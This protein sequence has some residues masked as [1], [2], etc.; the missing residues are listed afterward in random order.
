MN[1]ISYLLILFASYFIWKGHWQSYCYINLQSASWWCRPTPDGSIHVVASFLKNLNLVSRVSDTKNQHKVC[2]KW[3]YSMVIIMQPKLLSDFS[4]DTNVVTYV[5]IYSVKTKLLQKKT[6]ISRTTIY[7]LLNCFWKCTL[8]WC[9]KHRACS[10]IGLI[11]HH[12]RIDLLES[13]P[14]DRVD[15]FLCNYWHL[16]GLCCTLRLYL[17]KKGAF[18]GK[19]G[20]GWRSMKFDT[21]IA[22]YLDTS[23]SSMF[24]NFLHLF[25]HTV[26]HLSITQVL[27]VMI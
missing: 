11:N 12:M 3:E 27:F 20:Y 10:K 4:F 17:G 24:I 5:C 6:P 19:G 22:Q 25:T 23:N 13:R 7:S 15:P 2:W 14:Y 21:H 8:H 16:I 18:S 9:L 1:R 26:T